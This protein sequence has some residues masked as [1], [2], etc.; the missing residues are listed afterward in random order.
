M[1]SW[2]RLLAVAG[3]I[4]TLLLLVGC[5][6]EIGGGISTTEG[7]DQTTTTGEEVETTTTEAPQTTTTEAPRPRPRRRPRPLRP[8]AALM[9]LRPRIPTRKRPTPGNTSSSDFSRWPSS[10]L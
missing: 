10:S 5:N 6:G 3:L 1:K 2:T 9:R 4:V 8:P 7:G